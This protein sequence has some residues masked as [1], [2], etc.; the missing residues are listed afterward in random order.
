MIKALRTSALAAALIAATSLNAAAEVVYHRGN[1]ADP[2]TLDQH[3]TSTTYEANILRD[4]YEGLVAYSAQGKIIPGVAESWN[5]SED[6]KVYTF[7]LREDAKWS[8]GDPV[9]AGD[10]VYSLR[11]ILMPE[12]GAK[13]AGVLYPIQNAEAINQGKLGTEELGVKAADD[14]TL[15]ITLHSPTPYFLDLLGHQ[16]GLPVHPATVE[17]HG[18]DFVKPENIVTNGP[19]VLKSFVPNDTIVAQKNEHYHDAEN[20]KIDKVIFYP[21]ED[22]GAALRRFQAGEL[23]TNNDAPVEQVPFMRE[24]LG[25]QFRVA[26]YLGTYYYAFNHESDAVGDADVRQALSMVIDREFLADEIWGSTMV[27]AYSFVPEGIGNYGDPAYADWMDMD[28]IDR[29]DKAIEILESKGYSESNPLQIE[30][31]YNTSE[32]HKNTAVAVA[33]MWKPLGVEVTLLNTD[34]KTHYAHLRDRGDFDIARAGWI[35]DYSDP[36]NFL[37]L[38][39]SYNSGFNYARYNK[40]DYD[41]LMQKA[42]Q[43]VDLEERAVVLKEAETMFMRDLPFLPLMYYGSL[44]LVSDKVSGFEDNLMNIHPSRWVSIAE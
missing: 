14:R 12:T 20:V 31:R 6:G 10:F 32:N 39:E 40:P 41:A 17:A 13:Y 26:P 43:T 7:K 22:R 29:E 2:E 30:I 4:L 21:T 36:Q 33:D 38:V 27:P 42:A 15:E 11:R 23:H 8:N 28:L 35:G 1:T 25:N 5:V 34:T 37:F 24:N 19:F 44:S 3:K 16:T 9:V 18:S